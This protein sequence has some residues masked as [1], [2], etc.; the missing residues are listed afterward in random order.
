MGQVNA[1][2]YRWKWK[3]LPHKYDLTPYSVQ[4]QIIISCE[5]KIPVYTAM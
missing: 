2:A 3:I 1:E 5:A 4:T